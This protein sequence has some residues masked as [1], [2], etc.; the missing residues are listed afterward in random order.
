MAKETPHFSVE[1]GVYTLTANGKERLT[2]R[3]GASIVS[4]DVLYVLCVYV[5]VS[6]SFPLCSSACVNVCICVC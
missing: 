1:Q 4:S 2:E 3:V 5:S 6:A